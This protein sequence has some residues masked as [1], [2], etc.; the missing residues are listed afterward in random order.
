MIFHCIGNVFHGL[1][2]VVELVGDFAS[3]LELLVLTIVGDIMRHEDVLR[4]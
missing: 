3:V 1:H 2:G 4:Q